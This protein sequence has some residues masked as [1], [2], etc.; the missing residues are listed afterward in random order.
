MSYLLLMFTFVLSKSCVQIYIKIKKAINHKETLLGCPCT[1]S[2]GLILLSTLTTFSQGVKEK[3]QIKSEI[4]HIKQKANKHKK[5]EKKY[6][7]NTR[8]DKTESLRS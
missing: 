4:L 2:L 3:K 6:R 8:N 5:P 7:I 1:L